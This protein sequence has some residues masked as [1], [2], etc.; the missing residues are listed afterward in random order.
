MCSGCWIYIFISALVIFNVE[1]ETFNNFFDA[2]YWAIVSFTTI[3]YGDIYAVSMAGKVIMIILS[4]F[5]L[6]L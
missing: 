6:Q 4:V 2:I 1:P 5:G 3:G